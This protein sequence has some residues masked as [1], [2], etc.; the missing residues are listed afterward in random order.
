RKDGYENRSVDVPELKAGETRSLDVSL[1]PA[2]I[3]HIHVTDTEGHP[4]TGR[5]Q[6]IVSRLQDDRVRIQTTHVATDEKGYA[7]YS[8]I[9]P[10]TYHLSLTRA[11]WEGETARVEIVPGDNTVRF[12]LR[13]AAK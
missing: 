1:R 7:R 5:F 3:L 6:I 10:G 8:R 9:A 13:P 12:R 2:A 4:L 11:G